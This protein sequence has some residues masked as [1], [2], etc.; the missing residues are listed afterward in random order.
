LRDVEEITIWGGT[1]DT[2]FV[3][4][5]NLKT[6]RLMYSRWYDA[7][8]TNRAVPT[9]IA[10]E[11]FGVSGIHQISQVQYASQVDM[12]QLNDSSVSTEAITNAV[13]ADIDA[14]FSFVG[15]DTQVLR[16]L[17]LSTSFYHDQNDSMIPYTLTTCNSK[18]NLAYLKA[19]LRHLYKPGRICSSNEIVL[20]IFYSAL[21]RSQEVIEVCFLIFYVNFL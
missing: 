20:E 14:L 9:S 16:G 10:I 19:F 18:L 2:S 11:S 6:I 1:V 13:N 21:T 17:K 3:E 4:L 15:N 7:F 12:L 8:G 5:S